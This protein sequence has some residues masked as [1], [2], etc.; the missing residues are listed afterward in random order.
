MIR[1]AAG[2]AL[3]EGV[4][5]SHPNSMTEHR[6]RWPSVPLESRRRLKEIVLDSLKRP[7]EQTG[8]C[9]A[10]LVVFI[11][12]VEVSQNEW[13]G[14]IQ[15]LVQNLETDDPALYRS[16]MLAVRLICE[17][18]DEELRTH[19]QACASLQA[20]PNIFLASVLQRTRP[21]ERNT[22]ELRCIAI[23]ALSDVTDCLRPGVDH[24]SSWKD[25]SSAVLEAA[26]ADDVQ[27][28]LAAFGCL[29][30]IM[31]IHCQ[32]VPS[33][34]RI[35]ILEA[36][37]NYMIDGKDDIVML[38]IEVWSNFCEK[39]R[40]GEENPVLARQ[41]AGRLVPLLLEF[42]KKEKDAKSDEYTVSSAAYQAL[43]LSAPFLRGDAADFILS[44]IE[45]NLKGGEWFQRTAAVS[46]LD[47]M[48]DAAVPN[49]LDLVIK[50]A[51]PVLREMIQDESVPARNS[52]CFTL[53]RICECYPAAFVPE[54]NLETLIDGLFH[55]LLDTPGTADSSYWALRNVARVFSGTEGSE[56]NRLSQHFPAIV[57]TL[58]IATERQD[59]GHRFC[60]AGYEV[61]RAFVF[62]SANDSLLSVSGLV[63]PLILR[64][65]MI[66]SSQQQVVTEEG[67]VRASELCISLVIVIQAIIQRL[68]T[69]I[70]PRIDRIVSYLFVS[71]SLFPKRLICDAVFTTFS[72]VA[73]I[74]KDSF[75]TFLD[76]LKPVIAASF[77]E[78]KQLGL[79][80]S[81]LNLITD[82]AQ[83]LDGAFQ[84]YRDH[85]A[86]LLLSVL[87]QCEQ[88]LLPTLIE[89]LGDIA[90]TDG[91]NLH[92]YLTRVGPELQRIT[93]DVVD[94]ERAL[95]VRNY[96]APIRARVLHV[97]DCILSPCEGNAHATLLEPYAESIFQL[98]RSIYTDGSHD[99]ALMSSVIGIIR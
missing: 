68:G 23:K 14:L 35:S 84:P 50:P 42:L 34:T 18:V 55:S 74:A 65:Q 9:A 51:L 54:G 62:H 45:E 85:F 76:T 10:L 92:T 28:R 60:I 90:P 61:L 63:E 2:I 26:H 66:L 8:S 77:S 19:I 48:L 17:S 70:T 13:P 29:S 4:V 95:G 24:S 71:L 72:A 33:D 82:I 44:F 46:A 43:R 37:I 94:P 49:C 93:L 6:L 16:S 38:A 97:W 39:I 56:S 88:R 57:K 96:L 52:T 22:A 36:S 3:R 40:V 15:T 69:A 78:P 25:V 58:L 21:A 27:V 53:G 47:A 41:T 86:A 32:M 20:C 98:L 12:A 30:H 75:A 99:E 64:L 5:S 7:D 89:V 80:S 11:A 91:D 59:C 31:S 67:Q 81:A 83:A 73:R 1:T 79:W 87:P